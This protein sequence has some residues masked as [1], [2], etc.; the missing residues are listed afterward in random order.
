VSEALAEPVAEAR[1]LAKSQP[2]AHLDETG[3]REAKK[4]AWL[5]VMVTSLVTVYEVSRSRGSKI[6]KALLGVDWGGIL[7]SDRWSAYHWV[8][9][10]QRQFCWAHLIRDFRSVSEGTGLAAKLGKALLG[11]ADQMF[12]EWQKVRDGTLSR[13]KFRR[14]IRRIP[15][16]VGRLLRR[17]ERSADRAAEG[18]ARDLL[19]REVS[20]WTFLYADGVEPTNNTAERAAR[21]AV[22]WRK[23]SFGTD[24]ET[25]SRYVE[26]MLTAVATLRQNN[27]H[28]LDYLTSAI[29]ASLHGKPVP[30][31]IAKS[32]P[33]LR[34]AA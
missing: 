32:R 34:A 9:M 2:V 15:P 11:Q 7:V 14:R 16:R 5:W 26:R 6:A 1:E 18:M 22:L 28:V 20:L 8:D 10:F 33:R 27:R 23:G 17:L 13:D 29:T 19:S 4:K 24:S 12:R 3:W 25:G 30:S 31:F 21:H